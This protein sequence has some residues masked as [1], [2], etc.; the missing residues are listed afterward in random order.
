MPHFNRQ[1][2]L[3]KN[4]GFTLIE[5]LIV[6]IIVGVL[7]TFVSLNIGAKP[8]SAKQAAQQLQNL[9]TLAQEEAILKGHIL[10]W[11]ISPQTY[12]FYRYKDKIWQPLS[13]DKILRSYQLQPDLEYK[14]SLDNAKVKYDKESPPQITLLPDGSVNDFTLLIQLIDHSETYKVFTE[15]GKIKTLL[16]TEKN[17]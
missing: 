13:A 17:A 15:Q 8:S 5:L 7:M 12:T 9:L 16:V 1:H 3:S 6:L 11:K 10:G 4:S 14:L 2:R